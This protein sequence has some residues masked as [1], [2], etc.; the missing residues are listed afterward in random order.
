[1]FPR[2]GCGGD[3]CTVPTN[4]TIT[5]RFD[6]FLDPATVNRQAIFVYTGDRALGSPFTFEVDYD[7][8]ERVAEFALGA[9]RPY[10]PNTLYQY[11]L[12]VAEQAGDFGIRAFDGSPLE[13]ADVPL[14]GSFV[15][16]DEPAPTVEAAPPPTCDTIVSELFRGLGRCAGSEC[17]R[18]GAN[19]SLETMQDLGAAPH[20][21]WLDTPQSVSVSAINRVA[22]QTDVGDYSGGIPAQKS[23]RFG[24]RM[25]LIEPRSPGSSY[26]LYKLLLAEDNFEGCADAAASELCALPG[27]CET[28]HPA[29]P[30]AEGECLAPPLDELERIREWFVQGAPMPRPDSL[31]RRGNVRIQ[32]LRALSSF[33]SAGADCSP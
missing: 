14:R 25:A 3:D 8:I 19:Q 27:P 17:H 11:E 22:R 30:L 24:A 1:M 33:I 28:A 7:P 18:R 15:T 13:E 32:G 10:R 31:G 2:D 6:R 23:P 4:A 5:I 20:S 29:L 9:S 21:L 26:L 12:V 16:S